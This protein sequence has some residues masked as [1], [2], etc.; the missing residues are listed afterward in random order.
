MA[1]NSEPGTVDYVNDPPLPDLI[2]RKKSST[3]RTYSDGIPWHSNEGFWIWRNSGNQY[4]N[5]VTT[6]VDPET[7]ETVRTP[8]ADFSTKVCYLQDYYKP[9][10]TA[11]QGTIG[12]PLETRAY[13]DSQFGGAALYIGVNTY[14]NAAGEKVTEF[15]ENQ[16]RLGLGI[17]SNEQGDETILSY[18]PNYAV[19]VTK[20][21]LGNG[22][23]NSRLYEGSYTVNDEGEY[24]GPVVETYSVVGM[25]GTLHVLPDPNQDG[26]F[27]SVIANNNKNRHFIIDRGCTIEVP[28]GAK[29]QILSSSWDNNESH[30]PYSILPIYGEIIGDGDLLLTAIREDFVLV[31]G[32]NNEFKGN[33]IIDTEDSSTSERYHHSAV[34]AGNGTPDT[35]INN[36]AS[37][38]FKTGNLIIQNN[39]TLNNLSSDRASTA[40]TRIGGTDAIVYNGFVDNDDYHEYHEYTPDHNMHE[41]LTLYNDQP[42]TYYGAIGEAYEKTIQSGDTTVHYYDF[43]GSIEGLVK[44]GDETLNLYCAGSDGG[45]RAESFVISSG[46]INFNGYFEGTL[47]V[48]AN[49]VFSPDSWGWGG[50]PAIAESPVQIN[51]N[52]VNSGGIIEFNFSKFETGKFDAVSFIN[53]GTFDTSSGGF[54]D[55]AFMGKDAASWATEDAEYLLIKGGG[56]ED[57]DYSYLLTEPSIGSYNNRG[58][59]LLGK[60]GNLYLVTRYV[61]EPS[62]WAL[63][64]LGAAGLLFW[65]KRK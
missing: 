60:N 14:L 32:K 23:I 3:G 63:L 64:V 59:A 58:F 36:A 54:I 5:T 17:K 16:M 27:R 1:Q 4:T 9:G 41:T 31:Y 11:S 34:I 29:L 55:L 43:T 48:E 45:I 2:L 13:L 56:F 7:G 28:E 19:D 51:G 22:L 61:P 38:H 18:D 25:K 35:G 46:R 44:T 50:D 6:T 8:T 49:T 24:V 26:V 57:K 42:T 15:S 39:Q 40:T 52:L 33:I 10:N 47:T 53:D 65:R 21:Y 12:V 62:T 37:V 20:V 30:H